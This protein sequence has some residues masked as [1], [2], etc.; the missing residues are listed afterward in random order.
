MAEWKALE[1]AIGHTFQKPALLSQALT[2]PSM[3]HEHNQRLE[4]LGDAVLELCVSEK[5]DD[6]HP[7]MMREP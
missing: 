3:G 5:I 6:Q 1:K 7:E 4:Y 2:H